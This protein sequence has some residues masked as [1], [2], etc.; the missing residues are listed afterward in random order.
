MKQHPL[1]AIPTTAGLQPGLDAHGSMPFGAARASPLAFSAIDLDEAHLEKRRIVGQ[2]TGDPRS[3][4]F[5]VL[6]TQVVQSLEVHDWRLMGVT[7]PTMGCGKTHTSINLALSIARQSHGAAL[8][9]DMDLRKPQLASRLGI[10]ATGGL[11]DVL[12]GRMSL[13]DAVFEAHVGANK[14]LVLPT[15]ATPASSELMGSRGMRG[16]LNDLKTLFPTHIVI[17]DL[18]PMLVGDEVLSILPHVDCMLLVT[19]VGSSTVA[20]VEE[21]GRHLQ[22]TNLVRV[23]VNKVPNSSKNYY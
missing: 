22:S 2:K 11:I 3:K 8:L 12:E 16:F 10:E 7:S 17:L 15:E 1:A 18:P 4:P 9:V 21:C 20:E 19:A 6:R 13:R 14:I 23:V 5:D